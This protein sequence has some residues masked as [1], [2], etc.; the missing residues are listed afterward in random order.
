MKMR[1]RNGTEKCISMEN[2]KNLRLLLYVL[3]SFAL[4]VK[5]AQRWAYEIF[6]SYIVYIAYRISHII[7]FMFFIS[8]HNHSLKIENSKTKSAVMFKC[9]NRFKSS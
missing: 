1:I 3:L 7:L 6:V 8:N 2:E 4:L 5:H 9:W